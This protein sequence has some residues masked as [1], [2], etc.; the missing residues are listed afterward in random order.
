MKEKHSDLRSSS[1]HYRFPKETAM[2]QHNPE[3]RTN[4]ADETIVVGVNQFRFL[5]TGAQS[6]GSAALCELT[7]PVG[8]KLLAPAHS[9]DT[10]EETLY[11]LS[12]ITTFTVNGEVI[13]VGPGQALCIPRGAI[14]S[15]TNQGTTD[16]KSLV[17][18]SP[19]VIGPEVF[20]EMS[21]VFKTAT[22]G[23]PDWAQMAEIMRRYDTTPVPTSSA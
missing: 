23:P 16:A 20:R 3:I 2:T 10:Y 1:Y 18:I 22:D 12:G 21:A 6:N 5:V 11:G 14:H 7:V 19:A 4:P 13:D 15:F 17:I 9:H 8:G